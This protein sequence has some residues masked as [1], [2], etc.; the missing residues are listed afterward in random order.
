LL[1]S[2]LR[3]VVML[4]VEIQILEYSF[5]TIV[6]DE[7]WF[8]TQFPLVGK[9]FSF[10]FIDIFTENFNIFTSKIKSIIYNF[11]DSKKTSNKNNGKK[12]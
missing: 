9:K 5:V 2:T 12:F 1:I 3:D 8:A 7:H 11:K 6:D 10:N 4:D